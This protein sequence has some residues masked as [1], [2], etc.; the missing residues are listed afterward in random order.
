MSILRNHETKIK[1]LSNYM[2]ELKKKILIF[3]SFKT[4]WTFDGIMK[5]ISLKKSFFSRYWAFLMLQLDV[6]VRPTNNFRLYFIW[7]TNQRALYTTTLNGLDNYEREISGFTLILVWFG[8]ELWTGNIR[9]RIEGSNIN[10]GGLEE[11]PKA[12]DHHMHSGLEL[13]NYL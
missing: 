9:F 1:F 13:D 11:V 5:N 2:H 7:K 3:V 8:L 10:P 4:N 12:Q 6:V